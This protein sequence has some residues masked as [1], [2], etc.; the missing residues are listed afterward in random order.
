MGQRQAEFEFADNSP[1]PSTLSSLSHFPFYTSV[2]RHSPHTVVSHRILFSPALTVIFI[3]KFPFFFL[4]VHATC[5]V[6]TAACFLNV[7]NPRILSLRTW[8]GA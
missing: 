4:P 6:G 2:H 8:V 7:F 1:F 3:S 5:S